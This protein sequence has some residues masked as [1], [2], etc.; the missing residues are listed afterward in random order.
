[1]KIQ[2]TTGFKL[3]PIKKINNMILCE[4]VEDNCLYSKGK[5]SL[6]YENDLRE[7]TIFDL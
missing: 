4:Y 6:F 2:I 7:A 5:Q 3:K 1:M